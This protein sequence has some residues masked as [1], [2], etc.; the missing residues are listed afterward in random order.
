[1][2]GGITHSGIGLRLEPNPE[3][4]APAE[5]KVTLWD[6]SDPQ[7]HLLATTGFHGGSITWQLGT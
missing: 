5:L 1:M 2:Y 6:G 4:Y 3:T 7:D